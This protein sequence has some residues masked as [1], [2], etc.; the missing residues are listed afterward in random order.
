MHKNNCH[1][2]KMLENVSPFILFAHEDDGAKAM[3]DF[4]AK[5]LLMTRFIG[6]WNCKSREGNREGGVWLAHTC[7]I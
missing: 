3:Q 7:L 5:V 4:G 2:E 6:Y 1:P